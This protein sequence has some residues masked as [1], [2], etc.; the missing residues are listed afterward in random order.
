MLTDP[1][2]VTYNGSAKTLPRTSAGPNGSVFRTADGE[3]R[4]HIRSNQVSRDG[5]RSVSIQ[6]SRRLPD[7]TPSDAFDA[8]RDI[9]NS[10]AVTYDFDPTRA[11]AS[12]DLPRLRTAL[13]A[14]VDST[15][16]SRLIAGEH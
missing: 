15:L 10:F 7:P 2:A 1:L 11:E 5:G 8:Y 4:I 16:E 6:L 14:F 13:L 9:R 12:V 3:F